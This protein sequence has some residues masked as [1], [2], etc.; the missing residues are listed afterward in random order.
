[1]RA[2]GTLQRCCVNAAMGAE[3]VTPFLERGHPRVTPYEF[4][5]RCRA[6]TGKFPAWLPL[7]P[8]S[9]S[10]SAFLS[11]TAHKR[12]TRQTSIGP[13]DSGS[14]LRLAGF[15]VS[16]RAYNRRP[17]WGR[18]CSSVTYNE[19]YGGSEKKKG[20]CDNTDPSEKFFKLSLIMLT[21]VRPT[22]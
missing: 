14:R 2:A 5:S 20:R 19:S 4:G 15:L 7:P 10:T 21:T 11:A 9:C 3:R 17:R 6:I 16:P 13:L 1:M 12:H 18:R 8:S 22:H